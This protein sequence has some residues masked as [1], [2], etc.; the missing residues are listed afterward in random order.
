MWAPFK[1]IPVH[2]T[3]L[4]RVGHLNSQHITIFKTCITKYIRVDWEAADVLL[5][6][7]GKPINLPSV[8][9]VSLWSSSDLD[10]IDNQQ[11][12]TICI[13]GRVLDQIYDIPIDRKLTLGAMG[14]SEF[15]YS[16]ETEPAR[17]HL[18]G[19]HEMPISV[20]KTKCSSNPQ[21]LNPTAPHTLHAIHYASANQ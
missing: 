1:Q 18:E 17:G 7:N 14:G 8:G 20:S 5:F 4:K 3:L 9:T 15:Q 12:Y 6:Y 21:P 19:V 2:P 10:C 16:E 13:L 11:Q